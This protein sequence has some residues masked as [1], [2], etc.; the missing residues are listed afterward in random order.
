MGRKVRSKNDKKS[1][2]R[3]HIMPIMSYV[4][5]IFTQSSEVLYGV[6]MPIFTGGEIEVQRNSFI[7]QTL[8]EQ[9]PSNVPVA[10]RMESPGPHGAYSLVGEIDVNANKSMI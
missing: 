7:Q 4:F 9:L 1:L 5:Y 3:I 8:I 10:E 6:S 2:F